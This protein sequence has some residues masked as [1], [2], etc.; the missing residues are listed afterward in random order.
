MRK[1]QRHRLEA[2]RSRYRSASLFGHKKRVVN[3]REKA[4]RDSGAS[5]T[6]R[7]LGGGVGVG[8]VGGGIAGGGAERGRV[9]LAALDDDTLASPISAKGGYTGARRVNS[10]LTMDISHEAMLPSLLNHP[11]GLG[12]LGAPATGVAGVPQRKRTP[13]SSGGPGMAT[14]LGTN[15]RRSLARLGRLSQ[16]LSGRTGTPEAASP[17]VPTGS[18][19]HTHPMTQPF[20]SEDN[21][22]AVPFSFDQPSHT[23]GGAGAPPTSWPISNF[24][25]RTA[26]LLTQ[27]QLHPQ[28]SRNSSGTAH[29]HSNPNANNSANSTLLPGE[30]PTPMP[31]TKEALSLARVAQDGTLFMLGDEVQ[32]G[33]GKLR[34]APTTKA[35]GPSHAQMQT[36]ADAPQQQQQPYLVRTVSIERN[37][38]AQMQRHVEMLPRRSDSLKRN[39]LLAHG[40]GQV[41]SGHGQGS[42]SGQGHTALVLHEAVMDGTVPRRKTPSRQRHLDD[43][44]RGEGGSGERTRGSPGVDLTLGSSSRPGPISVSPPSRKPAPSAALVAPIAR[45]AVPKSDSSVKANAGS[46]VGSNGETDLV[47]DDDESLAALE[48]RHITGSASGTSGSGT[49]NSNGNGNKNG[50]GKKKWGSDDARL[51]MAANTSLS[52]GVVGG[53]SGIKSDGTRTPSPKVAPSA[54]WF[55][56]FRKGTVPTASNWGEYVIG[57]AGA[58]ADLMRNRTAPVIPA[59]GSS[60]PVAGTSSAMNADVGRKRPAFQPSSSA[61]P[62]MPMS[63]RARTQSSTAAEQASSFYRTPIAALYSSTSSLNALTSSSA[64][65]PASETNTLQRQNSAQNLLTNPA[66]ITRPAE[67]V[68]QP[69]TRA[70]PTISALPITRQLPSINTQQ[71]PPPAP[72]RSNTHPAPMAFIPPLSTTTQPM[73]HSYPQRPHPP[74]PLPIPPAP[75]PAPAPVVMA[76]PTAPHA[77]SPTGPRA[78]PTGG[79]PVRRLPAIPPQ[80]P[81]S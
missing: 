5:R 70:L 54:E 25:A 1:K 79:R 39:E 20:A 56:L 74:A 48:I 38:A 58:K 72:I 9:D 47:G 18:N 41:G 44:D 62:S 32:R 24:D 45:K 4:A 52:S 17:D 3:M 2:F 13:S 67:V 80:S 40:P 30:K 8:V 22:F 77:A 15:V 76:S 29:A 28:L 50:K 19:R 43:L 16:P 23:G 49:G 31:L 69:I 33:S 10:D 12:G 61:G 55:D 75:A 78:A 37:S 26:H 14:R 59:A 65:P 21:Q 53:V 27:Q 11:S 34:G 46:A 68:Q 63:E 57:A 66:P 51:S 36:R 73:S 6:S 35:P 81:T 60:K 71:Q 42:G 7:G 64:A